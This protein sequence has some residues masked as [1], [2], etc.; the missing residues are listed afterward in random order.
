MQFTC[1]FTY[2]ILHGIEV[3]KMIHLV[4]AR[5]VDAKNE[6]S[7]LLKLHNNNLW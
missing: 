5:S 3:D 6:K 2:Y 7:I 4:N 1:V